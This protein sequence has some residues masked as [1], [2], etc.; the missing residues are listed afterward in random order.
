LI[1]GVVVG[2]AFVFI[3]VLNVLA[4]FSWFIGVAAGGGTY[5]WMMV[6]GGAGETRAAA[7]RLKPETPS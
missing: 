6:E 7:S 5:W 4:P 2:S 1:V 3:P